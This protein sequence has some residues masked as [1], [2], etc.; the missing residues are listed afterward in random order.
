MAR[1]VESRG[2]CAARRTP[3]VA[4]QSFHFLRQ[5]VHRSI[6]LGQLTGYQDK[7]L[8]A[9]GRAVAVVDIGPHDHVRHSRFV[10][11]QQKDG[12]LGGLRPLANDNQTRHLTFDACLQT[13]QIAIERQVRR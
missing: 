6:I 11:H 5:Y 10:F 3:H 8:A 4:L 2:V 13:L 1:G 7:G 9:H 12:P